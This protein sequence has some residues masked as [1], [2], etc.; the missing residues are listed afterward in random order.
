MRDGI[1]DRADE[2]GGDAA[3]LQPPTAAEI[4]AQKSAEN[5]DRLL[6]DADLLLRLQLS[7]Y[8]DEVWDPIAT[9]FARYGLGVLPAWL[10]TGKMFVEVRKT[11]KVRLVAHEGG[12][13]P[14]T[15]NDL[16]TD[17]VVAAL[18][19][20]LE[21]LKQ[22]RWDPAKGASLKT[23]FLGKCKWEFLNVYRKWQRL[24]ESPNLELLADEMTT[25]VDAGPAAG[26]ADQA[27]L[28]R[29]QQRAV[30]ALLTTDKARRAFSL[31]DMGYSHEEIAEQLGVADAKAVENLLVY[32]RRRVQEQHQARRRAQ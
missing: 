1:D 20:F 30:L 25:F 3:H 27:L 31:A 23:Y 21:V 15:R 16:A 19:A 26:P 11:T 9:E 4:K 2:S 6:G 22:K 29:E 17:T 10:A 14:E 18:P 12:F 28:S 8:A 24:H 13:D 5:L 7:G 32:Q